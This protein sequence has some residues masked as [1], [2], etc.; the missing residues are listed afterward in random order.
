MATNIAGS[1]NIGALNACVLRVARLDTDC[2]PTGGVNGG[3]VTSALVTLTADPD[4]EA[5]TNFE[6]KNGC[7]RTLFTYEQESRLKRYNLSGELGLFDWEVMALLFGGDV[8]LGRSGGAFA[9]KVIG[10]SDRLY[11]AAPRNGVYLEVIQQAVAENFGPCGVGGTTAVAPVAIGHIFGRA[12]LTPGSADA[13]NDVSMVRFSGWGTNN[14]ALTNG[15]WND[16]PGSGYIPNAPK[17][18]VGYTQAE[19][20]AITAA[21]TVGYRDLPAG[22]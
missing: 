18:S 10:Y 13:G 1:V 20:D 8:V 16:F 22:S 4:V 15:P 7:G 3:I 14:P 12:Q 19:Y 9:G 6:P 21:V 2:T 5:G 11:S 17:V